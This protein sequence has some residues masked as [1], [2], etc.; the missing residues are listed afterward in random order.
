MKFLRKTKY[1]TNS[2]KPLSATSQSLLNLI[3]VEKVS[4]KFVRLLCHIIYSRVRRPG[5]EIF[6]PGF[7]NPGFFDPEKNLILNPEPG[8]DLNKGPE[9]GLDFQILNPETGPK[10]D[11]GWPGPEK[12]GPLPSTG[13]Y[14]IDY[15]SRGF[16]S[17]VLV[18]FNYFKIGW[19]LLT[20]FRSIW[21]FQHL[22]RW[23]WQNLMFG[24]NKVLNKNCRTKPRPETTSWF[25]ILDPFLSFYLDAVVKSFIWMNF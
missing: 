2:R 16:N 5:P 23:N 12:P 4:W 22:V 8:Q 3:R 9:T 24:K 20:Q 11:P 7:Q 19:V 18:I 10:P 15:V 13:L 21:G 25:W 14:G 6:D 17:S 1:F